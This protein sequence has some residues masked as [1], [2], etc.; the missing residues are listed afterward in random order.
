MNNFIEKDKEFK[1]ALGSFMIAFS[2][3]EYGLVI[4]CT[5]TE[6]DLRKKDLSYLKYLGYTLEL[7]VKTIT[8]FINDNLPDLKSIWDLIK[9][10]IGNVN[11]ERRFLVHG[12]HNYYLPN[13]NI[14]TR[15]KENGKIVEKKQSAI[16]IKKL[17]KEIQH[18]N[19]GTN[20]INGQ[21]Y[22]FFTTARV[23]QWNSFVND[24]NKIVYTINSKILSDWKGKNKSDQK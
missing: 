13:E 8:E 10:N 21:F 3:L 14:S 20:G 22:I 5:L 16:E 18:I 4:L 6:F 19:T 9:I 1:E 2:E 17:A 24:D 12:F 11:R 23:N 7:K 15:I